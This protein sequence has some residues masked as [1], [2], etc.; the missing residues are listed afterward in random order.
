MKLIHVILL[1]SLIGVSAAK[2]QPSK[3][4][5]QIEESGEAQL[6]R[7]AGTYGNLDQWKA[8]AAGIRE[9][10]LRGAELLPAPGKCK[11]NP[12]IRNKRAHDGYT[13]ENVAFESLPG[14]FVTGNLYRPA[15]KDGPLAGIL[16]PHGHFYKPNGGGRFRDDM[17]KRCATLARMGSAVFAYDMIGWGE[18]DQFENFTFPESHKKCEKGVKLQLWNSI[19]CVDFLVWLEDVD[20]KRIGATGASG[21]GVQTFQLAAVDDRVAVSVPVVIVSAGCRGCMCASGMP[22][23]KSATH[24]TNNAEISALAAPRP[25]LI[26]S[27]GKDWTKNTPTVEFPHIRNVYRLYGAEDA[28]ENLHLPDEGHDYGL[29][30]RLGAYKFFAKHLDLSLDKVTKSDGSIDESSVVIEDPNLMRVF[31][32]QHPKPAH[33]VKSYRQALGS[34]KRPGKGMFDAYDYGAAG[35]GAALDTKAIQAAIDDCARAGGGKVC[36]HNGR[37]LSGT[38]RLRS[39]VTLYVE[40]GATLL[41]NTDV[42]E[43]PVIIPKCRSYTDYY[44]EQSLIYAENAENVGIAGRGVIDGQGGLF[45]KT[46]Y[47]KKGRPYVIRFSECRNVR[48]MDVV[49]RNSAM[50]MQHYLACENVVI[51]GISVWNHG[52]ENNDMI[53][54]D[55]CRDVVMSDCFGDSDDDALTLKSTLDRPCESVTISNC[56]MRS[57]RAAFKMGTE[58]NGGFR[59]ITVSNCVLEPSLG[60]PTIFGDGHDGREGISLLLVDGGRMENVAIS[61]I[62]IRDLTV[63]I[64]MRL[65]NRARPFT[66]GMAKPGVGTFRN[67]KISN[68]VATGAS[69]YGCAISGIPQQP[70]EN[71]TL[72]NIRISFVGGGTAEDSNA[73]VPEREAVYPQSYMFGVLPAYGFYVRHAGNVTLDNVELWC[74]SE[75]QRPAVVC[76]DVRDLEIS[77]L[78]ADSSLFAPAVIR[79]KQVRG[80]FIRGCRA[81]AKAPPFLQLEGDK[82]GGITVVNNDLS[83]AAEVFRRAPETQEDVVWVGNNRTK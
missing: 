80:A 7:F 23:H 65:G 54:I 18:S 67:V 68:V 74:E 45:A 32:Q 19:R 81:R 75:E 50:W 10:M 51:R 27:D 22:I 6:A 77:G 44:V 59:N 70:I 56:I 60:P 82:T 53:D 13:V 3:G 43:Y 71:V 26:I 31:T 83:G 69:K 20:P 72:S 48:I 52:N 38:I 35:D 24:E 42:N 37:F 5:D 49:L 66:A 1:F 8:R 41:G 30:K 73:N 14:F 62:V 34:E 11:L 46:H 28:V 79:L 15:S 39:N 29:S 55:G 47:S 78:K 17:Q 76:D 16:C 21:G 61:N 25:Q 58:S 63:P 40:A 36:L 64:F 9:G 2:S 4:S 33:A 57:N 12:I